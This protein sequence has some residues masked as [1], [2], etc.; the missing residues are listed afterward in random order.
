M[1]RTALRSPSATAFRRGEAIVF[2]RKSVKRREVMTKTRKGD[3]RR[4][5]EW[6]WKR[7]GRGVTRDEPVNASGKFAE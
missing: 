2:V 7:R 3:E 4:K 5:L 1:A 6:R